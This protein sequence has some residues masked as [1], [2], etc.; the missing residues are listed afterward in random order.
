MSASGIADA[1]IEVF[2]APGGPAALA[3]GCAADD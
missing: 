2:A 3:A 1:A